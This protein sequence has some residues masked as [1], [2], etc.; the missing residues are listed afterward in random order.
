MQPFYENN[1][2]QYYAHHQCILL[3]EL[4]NDQGIDSHRYLKGT[5]LFYDEIV[6]THKLMTA[7]QFI[8]FIENAQK[9]GDAST[10]FRWGHAMWPGHY[11]VFS[12]LV[13]NS[14]SLHQL[15]SVL[16]EFSQALCPLVKPILVE[17]KESSVIYW[18]DEIGVSSVS[19]FL[20]TAYSTAL[21]AVCHW[22]MGS[23]LTWRVCL[24]G[25]PPK[26]IEEYQVNL[27]GAI[28]FGCGVNLLVVNNQELNKPWQKTIP[29]SVQAILLRQAHSQYKFHNHGLVGALL[30]YCQNNIHKHISLEDAAHA[31]AMSSA[32]FK[33]KLKQ[34]NTSFQKIQDRARLRTCLYLQHEKQWSN[35]QIAQFLKFSDSNNFRKAFKRWCG[36]TPSHMREIL[37]EVMEG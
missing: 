11:D 5:G 7:H 35:Q 25:M 27:G 18:Q 29:D 32:T 22:L 15:L 4:L 3:M 36:Q 28:Q 8:K 19:D 21:S 34:H 6:K 37:L 20:M 33:R 23:K 31:F 12:Q 16:Q 2:P 10:P 24:Q 13:N 17:G 30:E 14:H 26:N 9:L 1:E